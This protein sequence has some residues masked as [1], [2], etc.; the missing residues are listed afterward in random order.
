VGSVFIKKK[1]KKKI[2]KINKKKKK[3]IIKYLKSNKKYNLTFIQDG[4]DKQISINDGNKKIIT[5]NYYFYGIY[6]QD[7]KLWIWASSIPGVDTKN[8]ENIKKIKSFNYL[9][10]SSDNIKMNFYYQLLTQDVLILLNNKMIMWINELLL[11]LSDSITI[12]N[13]LNSDSNIQFI[14]LSKINETYI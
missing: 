5:G 1:K 8:I 9:F 6:Q 13:P 3:K 7:T 12:F 4:S 11:Y 14:S 2:K 10:E